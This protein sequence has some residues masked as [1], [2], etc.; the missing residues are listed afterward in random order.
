MKTSATYDPE[1]KIASVFEN[2]YEVAV[3]DYNS[4]NGFE[5]EPETTEEKKEEYS[6]LMD[7]EKDSWDEFATEGYDV[8]SEQTQR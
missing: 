6:N 5:C 1:T 4:L 7:D 8:S 3:N 2:G